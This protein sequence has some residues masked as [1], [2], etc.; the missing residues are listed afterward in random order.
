MLIHAS[1]PEDLPRVVKE[2]I[3][4]GS[5]PRSSWE[6]QDGKKVQHL[7]VEPDVVVLNFSDLMSAGGRSGR[8]P[9]PSFLGDTM[10][11]PINDSQDAGE[12]STRVPKK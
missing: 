10:Q 4:G 2:N 5:D 7:F 12:L 8:I 11:Q 6:R 1:Q 3:L 9:P